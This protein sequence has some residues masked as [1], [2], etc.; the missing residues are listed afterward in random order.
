MEATR[1]AAQ[2]WREE[3]REQGRQEGEVIGVERGK[4]LGQR[5][6]LRRLLLT[7]FGSIPA[8]YENLL[9]SAD[10]DTVML[11]AGRVLTAGSLE[12]IFQS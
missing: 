7:R 2:R 6:L 3:G 10:T 8:S 5:Q 11:W 12:E 1:S 4:V 9:A